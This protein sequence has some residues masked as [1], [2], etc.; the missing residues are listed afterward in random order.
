MYSRFGVNND[1]L[2]DSADIRRII[3][4]PQNAWGKYDEI[5]REVTKYVQTDDIILIT[6]GPTATVMAYDLAM[7]GFQAVDIGQLDNEY[8][9]Y[10]KNASER[11]PIPG[12]MVAECVGEDGRG[13]I[14][15]K[16]FNN[17]DYYSQICAQI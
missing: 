15:N 13:I 11:T 6:L 9:W 10:L 7:M 2:S 12:K 3:C 16:A 1:L 5:L 14:D 4:P 17:P 8:E